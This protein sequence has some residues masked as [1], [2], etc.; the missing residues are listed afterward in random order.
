MTH[1]CVMYLKNK[2]KAAGS[3]KGKTVIP[4][5]PRRCRRPDGSNPACKMR[6]E[7][8]PEGWMK[9]NVDGSFDS[10]LLKGGIGVVIRDWEGAIIFASCKSVCRCSSPLEA[11]L[12]ALREGIYLFLIWTLRS[13]I[14]ET[15]CLVALQMIQSKERATS[16]LAYLV[17]E[18]RDL[19]NGSREFVLWKIR[20]EQNMV[21]H[22]LANKCRC[23]DLSSRVSI[24]Y[25]VRNNIIPE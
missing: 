15:D 25:L 9:A 6:W 5:T 3:V 1:N 13:V 20:R 8:P 12:L 11:E 17:R 22:F 10:Q 7:R 21:S 19:L 2:E 14:L 4:A 18:I 23:E 24:S 16:E